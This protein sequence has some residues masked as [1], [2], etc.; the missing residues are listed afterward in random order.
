MT[1]LATHSRPSSIEKLRSTFKQGH[2]SED[3]QSRLSIASRLLGF[4]VVVAWAFCD[5]SGAGGDSELMVVDDQ[6]RFYEAPDDLVTFLYEEENTIDFASIKEA[7]L[8]LKGAYRGRTGW[9]RAEHP[10]NF[11][12][13]F[14]A[15]DAPK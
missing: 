14:Y 3:V 9:K 12:K 7:G 10:H 2:T 5:V 1:A 13:R 15:G 6:G 11:T 4:T 8:S